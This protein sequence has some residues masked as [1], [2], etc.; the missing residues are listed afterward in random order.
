ME[1]ITPEEIERLR[2]ERDAA[3]ARAE[4]AEAEINRMMGSA[5]AARKDFDE[6]F[7]RMQAAEQ[8]AMSYADAAEAEIAKLNKALSVA[9]EALEDK[10]DAA[11]DGWRP[12]ESAPK[13]GTRF[14]AHNSRGISIVRW[15]TGAECWIRAACGS[16]YRGAT[17]WRP[18]PTPPAQ[19][20]GK[21]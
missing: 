19:E 7:T 16:E 4:A 13:D 9:L 15:A 8:R 11:S 2:A 18:L 17:H 12:I 10:I 1:R 3:L 5:T 14:L 21:P 6:T 20:E